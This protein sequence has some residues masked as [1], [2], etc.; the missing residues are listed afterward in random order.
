MGKFPT[1]PKTF[2]SV[3]PMLKNKQTNINESLAV[4]KYD[5]DTAEKL[6]KPTEHFPT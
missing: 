6:P 3:F 2:A 1:F 5:E 4:A